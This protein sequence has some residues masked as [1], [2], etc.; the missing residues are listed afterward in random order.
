MQLSNIINEIKK[1]QSFLCVG[2]DSDISKIPSHL[3]S[4]SDSIYL[5]NKYIIDATAEFSIAYKLNLAFYEVLGAKG[6]QSLEKTVYYIKETYPNIFVIADAKRGDIGNTSIQYAKAFFET[7]PFDA[8]T[9]NPYM[10]NDSVSP[11]LQFE[12]K[13]VILLALTSNVGA[14]DFQYFKQ[15][16]EMLFEKVLRESK[17]WGDK[18]KIMYVVGATKAE[19]LKRVRTIV[20]DYFLL[21]PGIGAQGG[22]LHQVVEY[23]MTD[24]CGLI[25]N[26]SRAIIYASADI[27]FDR[28]AASEA[29][30][31]QLEMRKLLIKKC[32]I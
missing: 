1:K 7:L 21:I 12:G 3:K 16:G 11:F 28:K 23:G 22:D 4:S 20:P 25:V 26:S 2:L 13:F 5:F 32:I 31:I 10:G 19:M 14:T 9:V 15:N 27:D 17:K 18:E 24:N 6:W 30:L 29:K 8:I